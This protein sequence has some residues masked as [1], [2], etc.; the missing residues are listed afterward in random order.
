MKCSERSSATVVSFWGDELN[1]ARTIGKIGK[2]AKQGKTYTVHLDMEHMDGGKEKEV[3]TLVIS[4]PTTFSITNDF[5]SW[6]NRWC[7]PKM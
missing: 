6:N 7:S 3:W 4:N 5:G 2:V 1:T